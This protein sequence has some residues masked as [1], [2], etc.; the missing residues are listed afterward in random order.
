MML[1]ILSGKIVV[2]EEKGRE[3]S[4]RIENFSV[5]K[6]IQLEFSYKKNWSNSSFPTE[7][8]V[9]LEFFYGKPRRTGVFL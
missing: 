8:L 4:D 9:E 6:L 1:E 5:E 7:N 2:W 3:W